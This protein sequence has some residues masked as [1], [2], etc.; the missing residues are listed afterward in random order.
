[1][2]AGAGRDRGR[3]LNA[4]AREIDWAIKYQLI[5]RY[6]AAHDLSLSAPQVAWANLA[7]HDIHR[8]RSCPVG[9]GRYRQAG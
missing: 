2:A 8:G 3:N 6:W 4:I 5:E 7:Y 9:P 1:M